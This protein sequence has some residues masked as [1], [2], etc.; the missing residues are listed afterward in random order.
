MGYFKCC[1]FDLWVNMLLEWGEREPF[2]REISDKMSEPPENMITYSFISSTK[3]KLSAYYLQDAI[4]ST[5]LLNSF[6]ENL[7]FTEREKK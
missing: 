4:K 1:E 3:L 7:N 2:V 6:L 5:D